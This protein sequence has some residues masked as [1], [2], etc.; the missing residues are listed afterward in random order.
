MYSIEYSCSCDIYFLCIIEYAMNYVVL[1]SRE[2]IVD[3]ISTL[4]YANCL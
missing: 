2:M 1:E 3:K 4:I